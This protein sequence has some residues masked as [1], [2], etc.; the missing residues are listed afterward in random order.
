VIVASLAAAV[1]RLHPLDSKINN[2]AR[3]LAKIARASFGR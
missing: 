1:L 3:Q 2:N